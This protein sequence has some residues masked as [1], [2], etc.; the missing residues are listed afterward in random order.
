MR[1]YAATGDGFWEKVDELG[2]VERQT[3]ERIVVRGR[4]VDVAGLGLDDVCV[5]R[6]VELGIK[7]EVLG[8]DEGLE[9][10]GQL[11]AG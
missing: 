3:L 4:D 11:G 7:V 5:R 8:G 1:A 10:R 2:H 9:V 6:V